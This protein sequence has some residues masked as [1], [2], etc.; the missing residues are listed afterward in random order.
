MASTFIGGMDSDKQT[1]GVKSTLANAFKK[2]GSQ[3][4]FMVLSKDEVLPKRE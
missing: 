2:I 4:L 1:A 3:K